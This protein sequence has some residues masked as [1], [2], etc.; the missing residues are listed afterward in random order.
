[1]DTLKH[2]QPGGE[3]DRLS[4][5]S[6]LIEAVGQLIAQEGFENLGL[7]K[8]AECAG[9]NKTLIYRYFDSLDGLIYAY[10]RQHD[11]WINMPVEMPDSSNVK[12]YLKALFRRQIAE[13]RQNVA[14][15]RLRRW[16]LTGNK[17]F[18]TL[19]REQRERNGVQ[20]F[21]AFA[22]FTPIDKERLRSVT[23][24]ID[25]GIIHLSILE[26][27][28]RMFNG[29]D[30][31]SDGGWEQ[32]ALGIETLIDMLVIDTPKQRTRSAELISKIGWKI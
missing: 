28:V 25:A 2:I 24:L 23:A 19:I 9:V 4:T 26:E 12:S 22:G 20:F 1:M 27:N 29:V 11:F 32:L 15:K 17:E 21:E 13:A 6:R 31:Q 7:R 18:A 8:V 10:V 16:E 30:I 14:L 3:R 5:E